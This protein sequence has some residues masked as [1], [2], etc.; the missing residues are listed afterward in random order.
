VLHLEGTRVV[1]REWCPD[2]LEAMHRWLSDPEVTRFLSWGARTL[3]DSARH[4]AECMAEQTRPDRR[5]YFLAMELKASGRVIG[6]AGFEWASGSDGAR[7]GR[8]GYFIEPAHWGRGYAAEAAELLLDL[9]FGTCGATSMAASCDASNRG[10][11]RVMQKLGMRREASLEEPGR[12][13]Y[14]MSRED[15]TGRRR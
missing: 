5:R 6:D 8:L 2:E 10:S 14:T 9:A 4:L 12:R 11:E 7:S 13:V 3:E 1:L 15:W